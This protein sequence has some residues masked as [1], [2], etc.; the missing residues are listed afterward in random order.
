MLA[1]ANAPSGRPS[2]SGGPALVWTASS[3]FSVSVSDKNQ[4][5]NCENVRFRADDLGDRRLRRKSTTFSS[6][7]SPELVAEQ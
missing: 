5:V 4:R 6:V 2:Q 3:R 1:G 7:I